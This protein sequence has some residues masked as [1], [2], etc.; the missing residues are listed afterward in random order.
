[1]KTPVLCGNLPVK[2][3]ARE[4]QHSASVTE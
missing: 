2:I 1:V 3:D 4:G